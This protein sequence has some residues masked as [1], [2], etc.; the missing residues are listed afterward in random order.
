MKNSVICLVSLLSVFFF[1][2]C[3]TSNIQTIHYANFIKPTENPILQSD[4][5]FTF[6][7]GDAQG[8]AANINVNVD[9]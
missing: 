4:S 9:T 5:T 7:S 6:I 3:K 1:S 2:H 8:T